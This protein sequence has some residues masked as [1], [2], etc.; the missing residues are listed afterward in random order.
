MNS[1]IRDLMAL[2]SGQ[3][4]GGFTDKEVSGFKLV[5]GILITIS[6]IITYSK[7]F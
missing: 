1:L 5:L 3:D 6:V 4:P 7:L 2:F